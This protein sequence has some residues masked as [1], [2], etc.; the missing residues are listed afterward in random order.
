MAKI[1]ILDKIVSNQIAAGE[2]VDRPASVVK[3]L[4]ENSIDAGATIIDIDIEDGG[5]KYIRIVDNGCGMS[6]EDAELAVERHA[7]SKLRNAEDLL[8]VL[9]LGFRGEALP[10][11]ASVSKFSIITREAHTD[12]ATCVRVEGGEVREI[13]SEAGNIGT[14]I[15]VEDLFFNLPARKKFLKSSSTEARY[16]GDLVTKLA[17]SRP[18]I[19]FSLKNNGKSVV[20]TTGSGNLYDCIRALFGKDL[21]EHL[22]PVEYTNDDI[23]LSGFVSTPNFVKNNRALQFLFVNNRTVNSK[24]VY[25]ALDTAYQSKIPKGVHAF[26]LLNMQIDTTKVDINVHP[27]KQEIKFSDENFIFKNIFRAVTT[28]LE[29]PLSTEKPLIE[30][31][32]GELLTPTSPVITYPEHKNTISEQPSRKFPAQ[33]MSIWREDV[34]STEAA[35]AYKFTNSVEKIKEV[36]ESFH[37]NTT[38]IPYTTEIPTTVDTFDA[39]DKTLEPQQ[40]PIF[41]TQTH[42]PQAISQIFAK[43]IL[44][45]LDQELLI[46]DQ[47]AAHERIIYDRLTSKTAPKASQELLIPDFIRLLRHEYELISEYQ[48]S[49]ANLGMR[50]EALGDNTIR[51]ESVPAEIKTGQTK[52]FI[53]YMSTCLSKYST[54]T[55]EEFNRE[56]AH[57]I[58][59]KSAIKTG[60]LLSLQAM[61]DLLTNLYH[62]NNPYTCPHG[63]PIISKFT[64]HELDRMFKRV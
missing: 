4:L 28:A 38:A 1:Q 32:T 37:G 22:L 15:I 2:V 57:S 29:F 12:L 39:T 42:I 45:T 44:A 40:H 46:I 35:E 33:E 27:Q 18:D 60:A 59:C 55:T 34:T 16:I 51:V 6:P 64:L 58:A 54:P 30:P 63:R 26:V 23:T 14:A 49:F 48:N 3:E 21:T 5:A 13:A 62:T 10:S 7:T 61:Q 41:E 9:S 53:E 56:I 17:L 8:H 50:L 52:E 47:H 31:H 36:P 19:K 25:A 43:Y 20:M 11:I 24:I